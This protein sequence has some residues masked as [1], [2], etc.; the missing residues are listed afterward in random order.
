VAMSPEYHAGSARAV[1][2]RRR[3]LWLRSAAMR[4]TRDPN[5]PEPPVTSTSIRPNVPVDSNLAALDS[6]DL[7]EHSKRLSHLSAL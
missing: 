3:M 4:A 7:D 5:T 2:V 1:R 6:E